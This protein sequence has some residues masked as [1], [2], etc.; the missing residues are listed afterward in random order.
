M[1]LANFIWAPIFV[2]LSS[3]EVAILFIVFLMMNSNTDINSCKRL[4][5]LQTF[6]EGMPTAELSA[7]GVESYLPVLSVCH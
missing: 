3:C 2:H 4:V 5:G 6:Y 7:K 1:A